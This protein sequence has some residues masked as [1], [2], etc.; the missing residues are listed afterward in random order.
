MVF[1]VL[2]GSFLN[3]LI[4]R[5]PEGEDFVRESSHCP[6]CGRIL[7]FYELIPILSYVMQK[8]EC[9]GCSKGISI[10][11]PLVE[12]GNSLLWLLIFWVNGFSWVTLCY[13]MAASLL[14]AISVI[15][16]RIQEIS[17]QLN[18]GIFVLG[19]IVT[20]LEGKDYFVDHI[21]GMFFISTLLIFVFVLTNGKGMGGGDVKLMASCGLL[22]GWKHISLAFVLGCLTGGIVHSL[23][24]KL[25]ADVDNR[26][27]LGPYLSL[28]VLVSM[29]W[30]TDILIWYMQ[31]MLGMQV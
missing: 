3:V 28:G 8:G 6:H 9:R 13:A 21:I 11:Y 12:A 7:Q 4:L 15:D 24:M 25:F 10:Q 31:N 18:L 30:G 5:I 26:L 20:L 17:P 29:L 19:V 2:V 14:L 1:G 23:L 16:V 27:A 22:L